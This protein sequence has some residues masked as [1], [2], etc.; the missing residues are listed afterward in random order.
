MLAMHLL[1]A[2]E[3]A[4]Q[5]MKNDP[6]WRQNSV[7]SS[8]GQGQFKLPPPQTNPL[9][10]EMKLLDGREV[11]EGSWQLNAVSCRTSFL[12]VVAD[13]KTLSSIVVSGVAEDDG[14]ATKSKDDSLYSTGWVIDVGKV[15]RDTKRKVEKKGGMGYIDM[16]LALY[17]ISESGSV[18]FWLPYE[19]DKTVSGEATAA[20]QNYFDT[21]VVCEVNEKRGNKECKMDADVQ[22]TVGGIE[23][24]E[25]KKIQSIASYLKKEICVQIPVPERAVITKRKDVKESDSGLSGNISS[26]GNADDIGIFLDAEV[27]N[28]AVSRADGACS[29]SHV[30]WEHSQRL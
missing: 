11:S 16:K 19:G 4:A 13:T 6:N 9:D 14:D 27:T 2:V 5:I 21:I 28:S 24:K 20:A 30:V 15:E 18:R 3:T 17:G 1:E 8:E 23:S 26:E 12:P 22:F 10:S 25:T 7:I 29:I